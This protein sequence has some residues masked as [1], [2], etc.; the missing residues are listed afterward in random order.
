MKINK[1]RAISRASTLVIS[2]VLMGMTPALA[3]TEGA[4]SQSQDNSTV[5][6]AD[7][8]VTATRREE[9]LRTVPVSVTAVT[10]TAIQA[11]GIT[12]VEN[13]AS[14][15]PNLAV[16]PAAATR[17]A[18]VLTIRGQVQRDNLPTL[19]PSVG[20]YV[21]DTYLARSFAVLTELLDVQRVEVLRGPQGTLFGRNTIGGAI[22]IITNK[23][24]VSGG[25]TG[26]FSASVGNFGLL[27]MS[28]AVTVPLIQDRL[29]IRYA[30]NIRKRDGYTHTFVVT[31]PYTG[32]GS[33]IREIDTNN[34]QITS[35]RLSLAFHPADGT[36]IDASY[37]Y[38]E[39]DSDGSLAV[40]LTGDI[41][42]TS[43]TTFATTF[44]NSPQRA[45]DFYSGLSSVA[46]Y[47]RAKTQIASANLTQD[48]TDDITFK[49]MGSYVKSS[50]QSSNNA[51]GIVTDSV[52][53]VQF[54]PELN[55][56][57]NQYTGEAQITGTNLGGFLDWIGGLY[58]FKE[59]GYD[60]RPVTSRPEGSRIFGSR[61]MA[62]G[63]DG[64][65]R[66]KSQS[67]YLSLTAHVTPQLTVRAGGRYT[68]D[69]KGIEGHNRLVQSGVCIYSPGPGIVTSTTP[70]GPCELRRTDNFSYW[71]YDIGVDYKLTDDIFV[72]A[73]TGNGYRGGGQQLR[74]VNAFTNNPF[75]PDKVVNYEAGI[76]ASFANVVNLNTAVFHVDYSNVQQSLIIGPPLA[77][78]TT[79]VVVNQG[80]ANVDGFEVEGSIRPVRGLRFDGAMGYNRVKYSDRTLVQPYSPKWKYSLAATFEQPIGSAKLIAAANFDH[81]GAFHADPNR[82]V[83]NSLIPGSDILGARLAVEF[84]NGLEVSVW[85]R[86]L[87][88]DKYYA[89]V[90]SSAGLLAGVPGA[91][92]TFGTTARFSF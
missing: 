12:N 2:T 56:R 39:E 3:Q 52:A 53:L 67:A 46:P 35:H 13:L 69:T 10:G 51:D 42:R 86:N 14:S 61:A 64:I 29:A 78:T 11:R 27:E 57:Q 73:K 80:S 33:I 66:N 72:Y 16:R 45:A 48:L 68:K 6:D 60:L 36:K 17:S 19:D 58:Y 90:L 8:V 26:T 41:A 22:R 77:P 85:G 24:D 20:V 54:E 81:S 84:D 92:R 71:I 37:Y 4:A 47:S 76:K 82:A 43:F 50:N 15:V 21:D 1:T 28:G 7:I 18:A 55:Q 5:N 74:A 23:P 65:A 91:P 44:S 49:L 34:D 87:T 59:T 9:T 32:P 25:L 30:G 83:P 79:T 89:Y 40:N 75:S 38:F 31:E 70:N 63:F 62:V 88:K